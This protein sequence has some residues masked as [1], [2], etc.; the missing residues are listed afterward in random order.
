MALN[1]QAPGVVDTPKAGENNTDRTDSR[2]YNYR[3]S[4]VKPGELTSGRSLNRFEAIRL[5]DTA[6]NS[7]IS[8]CR[9]W[10]SPDQFEKVRQ[11]RGGV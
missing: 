2:D 4:K 10:L 3:I 8:T 11:L 5:H 6:L 7:I 1:K 9:Y